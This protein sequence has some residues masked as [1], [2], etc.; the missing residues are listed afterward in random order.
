[1]VKKWLALLLVF[2]FIFA[3]IG[4]GTA[5]EPPE[6]D[7]GDDAVDEEPASDLKVGMVTDAG[8]IDDKSFNQGTWEGVLLAASD[9]GLETRYLQPGGTTEADYITEISNLVDAGFLFVVCPGF[10]FE[11]A[12]YDVQTRY[13]QAK[14]VILDGYPHAG[15]WVPDVQE[16]VVSIFFAEHEAGFLGGLAAALQLQEGEVGFIG[17]MEIPAVQKFNWG[18]QQGVLY[19]NENYDTNVVMRAENFIY[20]GTFDNV[21]GGQQL[22]AA[23]YDKGVDA[24]FAAAGG[25]GIGAINEAKARAAT[26][27]EVWI[28]G[29]DVDQYADGIYE[30][31]NSIILTSAMKGIDVAAYD[32]IEAEL[33]GEFPGGQIITMDAKNYGIGIPEENPNLDAEVEELVWQAFAA[34][35]D[36]SLVVSDEQGDL[37]R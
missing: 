7:D 30:G 36:G 34:M 26:G 33:N 35:Q 1:M 17:G 22:A 4:C 2:L 28:I 14:F 18:F 25:V 31:N 29:V 32:M 16:N 8:T 20:E 3:V 23:M 19:A 13:P 6:V 9:F 10:K 21:A 27:Q 37:I 24:I 15:D 11:T 12:I 5:E